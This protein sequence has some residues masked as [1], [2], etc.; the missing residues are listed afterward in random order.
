LH[1]LNE[2]SRLRT[3]SRDADWVPKAMIRF[4]NLDFVLY[5]NEERV[6]ALEA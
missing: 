6:R 3:A 5:G 4:R 2:L 1:V